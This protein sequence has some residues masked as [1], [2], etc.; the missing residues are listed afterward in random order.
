[1]TAHRAQGVT[2]ET[3]HTLVEATTNREVFYVSM[4][5]GSHSNIAY[6]ATDKLDPAHTIDLPGENPDATARTVLH[7]VLQHSGVEY[8]AHETITAEQERWGGIGQLAAEYETITGAA[9]QD[10][11]AKLLA[12]SGLTASQVAE[13]VGGETFGALA[14]VLRRAEADG[15]PVDRLMPRLVAARGFTDADDIASVL[16]YRLE[17]AVTGAG[18][19]SGARPRLIVGLIPEAGGVTDPEM[20]AALEERRELIEARAAA[21]VDA[22][23]ADPAS[24]AAGIGAPLPQPTIAGAWRKHLVTVAAYRDRYG[25][26]TRTPLGPAPDNDAQK[27]D[28]ARAKT[29]LA[30]LRDLA[31][32]EG[33]NDPARTVH[34]EGASRGL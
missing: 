20:R 27:I 12:A 23:L 18:A 14:A 3:A 30:K 32:T 1:M 13:A 11:W 29:A 4:T 24:W 26:T 15:H 9:Q 2:V 31:G 10:R 34:R 33:H 28:A 22:A 6:V 21:L 19:R 16:H 8:S 17:R 25:I 5:R 7:G